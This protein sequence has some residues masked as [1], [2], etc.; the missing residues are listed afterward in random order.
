[1]NYSEVKSLLDAGFTADEIRGMLGVNP[2]DSNP[3]NAQVFQQAGNTNINSETVNNDSDNEPGNSQD[4][5][6]ASADQSGQVPENPN[7]ALEEKFNQLNNTMAKLIKT[8]QVSNLKTN[9][10][11][12][13]PTVADINKQV[14]DIMSSII[15]PE[16]KKGD[17]S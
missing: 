1:M 17:V 15:R 2:Q 6:A 12:N 10:L 3:Q 7:N 14:D 5:A 13:A 16:H 4:P 8:I 9:S 11:D